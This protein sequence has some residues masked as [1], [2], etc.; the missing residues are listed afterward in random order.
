MEQSQQVAEEM[1]VAETNKE[2]LCI[3]H[4][5]DSNLQNFTFISNTKDKDGRFERIR[6]IGN[7]RM[8]QPSD[9][10]YRMESICV[11]LPDVLEPHHGYHHDCYQRFTANLKQLQFREEHT[12]PSY[13]K[14]VKRRESDESVCDKILF[15][16]D[17]IFCNKYDRKKIKV[18]G[19]WTTEA[20]SS[21]KYGDGVTIVREAERKRMKNF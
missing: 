9:S 13:G 15:T 3:V 7:L 20:L 16:Q 6:K 8:A 18:K 5:K 19:S 11:G 21:L 4:M 1:E 10:A 2:G 14:R 12:E 17:C